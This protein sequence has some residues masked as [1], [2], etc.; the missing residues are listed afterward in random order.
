MK[1]RKL[2]LRSLYTASSVRL[3]GR[4]AYPLHD[5]DFG[6][7]FWITNGRCLHIVNGQ[8]SVLKA[9]DCLFLR[10][11]DRHCFQ[12]VRNA[13]FYLNNVTFRWSTYAHIKARYFEKDRGFYGEL[14]KLPRKFSLSRKQRRVFGR[15]YLALLRRQENL[16]RIE[17]FL[18]EAFS[19]LCMDSLQAGMAQKTLPV[20]LQ[21]ARH[22]MRDPERLAKGV[23]EFYRVSGRCP[24]HV[25][26]EH[27]RLTGETPGSFIHRLRMERASFLLRSTS[28]KILD[29]ALD[30]GF[31]SL[32]HFYSCFQKMYSQT[33]RSYRLEQYAFPATLNG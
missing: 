26:R 22:A 9:G 32:S 30:C 31:E 21:N 16:C 11:W 28:Q 15:Y 19:E 23:P 7:I 1:I 24:E 8:K 5:H 13:P 12:G 4:N 10:P 17:Q 20:W 6:E 25:C 33:P 14:E 3:C 2:T 18:L 27:R 29:V